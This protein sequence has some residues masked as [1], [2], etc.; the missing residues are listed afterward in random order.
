[1]FF[2]VNPLI[3]NIASWVFDKI[4]KYMRKKCLQKTDIFLWLIWDR[5]SAPGKC[6]RGSREEPI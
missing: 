4:V 6:R 5:A 3:Q 1:M 2:K